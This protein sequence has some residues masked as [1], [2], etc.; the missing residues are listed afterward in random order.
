MRIAQLAQ[1]LE[2]L[3][4]LDGIVGALAVLRSRRGKAYDPALVDVAVERATAWWEAVQSVDPWD[5]A[6]AC[7]PS[8]PPLSADRAR[9]ALFVLADFAD[10]KSPWRGGHSRAVATLARDACGPDAEAAALLHDLGV[11]AVS[12]TVWDKAGAWTR[13]E[14]DRGES[15]TLVTDQLLR[16][17]P[18][19]AQYADA[20]VAAH[21][22]CDASGYHRRLRV[23]HLDAAQ[24]VVAVADV[25]QALVSD[26]P[27]RPARDGA[28]AARELRA[29]SAAGV[30][31]GEAVERVLAAAGHRRRARPA[32][33]AGLTPREAEVLRLLA[34]G[35]TVKEVAE[36]LTISYK[37]ADH[38]VQHIYTKLGVSTRG[39]AA[40]FAIEHGLVTTDA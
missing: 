10:L 20:A 2:V 30:L 25:Y 4:R 26:R 23:T 13:D 16:R 36:R 12:N 19:L 32:L 3:A 17:V 22:R 38:H 40:L 9:D 11:V 24:R 27:H 14:R 21:E 15:H 31:D 8:T 33:P 39:A 34:L 18:F 35:M 5:A 29:G 6:L 7:A 37:T 1:E 28:A